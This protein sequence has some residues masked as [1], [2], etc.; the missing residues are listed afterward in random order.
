GECGAAFALKSHLRCHIRLHTGERPY[1]CGVCRKTFAQSSHLL[2]HMRIHTGERP[3]Q[4]TKCG[5]AF[6]SDSTLT[7]HLKIHEGECPF[8]CEICT[9]AFVCQS[10]LN[11]H[12]KVHS[13]DKPFKCD[14]CGKG[15]KEESYI[16][17]HKLRKI[18]GTP[19]GL[20]RRRDRTKKVKNK[21]DDN[22]E[23]V[24]RGRPKGSKGKG[25]KK[26]KSTI[27]T[28]SDDELEALLADHEQTF[29]LEKQQREQKKI[30]NKL[31]SHIFI[32]NGIVSN[33]Q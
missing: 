22:G 11:N 32:R 24:K 1:V 30:E 23:H 19:R 26:T 15:F 5:K 3:Y 2:G 25:S 16:E 20:K 28:E 14:V 21:S 17:K 7:K 4:C 9:R 33:L 27:I 8:V 6:T 29:S 12:Y 10:W 31:P 13:K 18:C